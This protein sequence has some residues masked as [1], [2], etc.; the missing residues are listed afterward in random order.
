M[1]PPLIIVSPKGPEEGASIYSDHVLVRE[2]NKKQLTDGYDLFF[3]GVYKIL[4][5]KEYLDDIKK[6]KE[7]GKTE[8]SSD[9]NKR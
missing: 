6:K 1:L 4:T 2:S 8:E 3:P 9:T 5:E 7:I